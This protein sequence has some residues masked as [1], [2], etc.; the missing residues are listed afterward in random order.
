MRP[1][2]RRASAG[3]TPPGICARPTAPRRTGGWPRRCSSP[4]SG[5]RSRSTAQGLLRYHASKTPAECAREAR[6]ARAGPRA[7][8]RRWCGRS[9]PTY[10]AAARSRADDYRRWRADLAPAL[11]CSPRAELALGTVLV[12]ALA[13]G[14]GVDRRPPRPRRPTP[15]RGARPSWSGPLRRARLRAM[16]SARLGVQVEPFRRPTADARHDC[17]WPGTVV[18]VLGPSRALAPDE[19]AALAALRRR[20]AARRARA[21]RRPFRCLGYDVRPRWR[22][23]ASVI[24]AAGLGSAAVSRRPRGAGCAA[25]RASAVDSAGR[26][27]GPRVTCT[28]PAARTVDTLLRTVGGR[29]VALRA[30]LDGRPHGHAGGRRPAVL[31]PRPARDRRRARS[32]SAW[33]C[34]G[35]DRVIVDEYH[36]GFDASRSA[37]R[38]DAGTGR[39]ARRGAGPCCS[40]WPS[41]CSRCSP[42][43]SGSARSGRASSA[44]AARRW[45]TSARWPPRSPR[46][47]GTTWPSRLMVQGLRRRLSR[48]GRAGRGG[49]RRLARRARRR[50][51][52]PRGREALATLRRSHR[53]PASADDVLHAAD[54]VE[55]LWEELTPT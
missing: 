9:T 31:Q 55:T 33:S 20:S 40:W 37:E 23:S 42:P 44:G 47:R 32:R 51:R 2:A 14:A 34:R 24:A 43:A 7:A 13:V 45:S 46:P 12:L 6:L 15:T 50:V 3:A 5:W 4:S 18:A 29:P 27:R 21:R 28:A 16:R 35:T 53:R 39:S 41:A 36:H 8:A 30:T 19:G 10:S 22:D 52:T 48:A 17:A 1:A 49:A 11:A 54:A 26:G 38:R 25:R